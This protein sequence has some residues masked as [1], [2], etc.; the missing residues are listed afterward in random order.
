M[1]SLVR[2]IKLLLVCFYLGLKFVSFIGAV[3][4][5]L[6]QQWGLGIGLEIVW[7]LLQSNDDRVKEWAEKN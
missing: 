4:L 7:M 1:R 5:L 2:V 6:M 3:E